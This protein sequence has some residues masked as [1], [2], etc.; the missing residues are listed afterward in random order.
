MD[1]TRSLAFGGIALALVVIL[2]RLSSVAV[3]GDNVLVL[4]AGFLVFFI[5]RLQGLRY[6]ALLYV[7]GVIANVFFAL[8]PAAVMFDFPVGLTALLLGCYDNMRQ[9]SIKMFCA[10]SAASMLVLTN[11]AMFLFMKL[12]IVSVRDSFFRHF[13]IQS[14][15]LLVFVYASGFGIITGV[16]GAIIFESF[17]LMIAKRLGVKLITPK[18]KA[19]GREHG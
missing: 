1:R 17:S 18:A 8:A 14:E 19:A 9:P 7:A 16:L 4:F 5:T 11:A 12:F 10:V 15:T 6:G 13:G 2:M 3:G